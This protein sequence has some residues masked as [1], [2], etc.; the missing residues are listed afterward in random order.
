M[1]PL[2]K[3][4]AE[5][6]EA[7]D[8]VAAK[9]PLRSVVPDS[10]DGVDLGVKKDPAKIQENLRPEL[11]IHPAV[12]QLRNALDAAQ[13]LAANAVTRYTDR[14]LYH[15]KGFGKENN[16]F[17]REV[18]SADKLLEFRSSLRELYQKAT[19][20]S[21]YLAPLA[22]AELEYATQSS[23]QKDLADAPEICTTLQ[24]PGS[25][26]T[27][28]A[29]RINHAVTEIEQSTIRKRM[30][31]AD[32]HSLF[33]DLQ[34]ECQ[35]FISDLAR[36]MSRANTATNKLLIYETQNTGAP[37]S[38]GHTQLEPAITPEL[39]AKLEGLSLPIQREPGSPEM[40]EKGG[41]IARLDSALLKSFFDMG[42]R[43]V[44]YRVADEI[45]G[46]YIYF[47][48]GNIPEFARPLTEKI[49]EGPAAFGLMVVRSDEVRG[50]PA[51]ESML[52][53][54]ELHL[55]RTGARTL[56]VR[57]EVSNRASFSSLYRMGFVRVPE[58]VAESTSPSGKRTMFIGLQRAIDPDL[59][60]RRA[61][62]KPPVEFQNSSE[63]AAQETGLLA[64]IPIDRKAP[65][66]SVKAH[67]P[68]I[69]SQEKAAEYLLAAERP[70][71]IRLTGGMGQ[72]ERKSWA[73][74][75]QYFEQE[76]RGFDGSW[77]VG[78]S[79]MWTK[80]DEKFTGQVRP[81]IADIPT[82]LKDAW[83]RAQILGALVNAHKAQLIDGMHLI[84]DQELR[85][86]FDK[87]PYETGPNLEIP[88]R[89][90]ANVEA[91]I[92]KL[93]SEWDVEYITVHE[94]LDEASLL[95]DSKGLEFNFATICFDG[96]D[97]TAR[98]IRK[99]GSRGGEPVILIKGS[100]RWTDIFAS[101]SDFLVHHPNVYVVDM[102]VSGSLRAVMME[103]GALSPR[104]LRTAEFPE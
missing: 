18:V 76:L 78:D 94:V 12:E 98:E 60:K 95:A 35:E 89:I 16:T 2:H 34:A 71:A 3:R 6:K 91:H 13:E 45:K 8:D 77:I 74:M 58:D 92:E 84:T 39:L 15:L 75:R 85:W 29:G 64:S 55:Q 103:L 67:V 30:L 68:G 21:D 26:V 32:S 86:N 82:T 44:T 102:Q 7:P 83:P 66:A 81:G 41:S 53:T 5:L 24:L 38:L 70:F 69:L 54:L 90:S 56:A 100:G 28:I 59:V 97:T 50:Q 52:E 48:P 42:A 61:R 10:L 79:T 17:Y 20:L 23:Y 43:C 88:Y 96:G 63:A 33:M 87:A 31:F 46:Y 72:M 62:W 57:M 27:T 99:A 14:A 93:E 11:K 65:E 47:E 73:K 9:P 104:P 101:D 51:M 4:I 80:S 37:Q 19:D 49:K 36:V 1:G 22:S 25:E 40:A